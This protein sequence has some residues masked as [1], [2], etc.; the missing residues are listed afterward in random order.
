MIL[1]P[2]YPVSDLYRMVGNGT[3]LQ[4]D[5]MATLHGVRSFVSLRSRAE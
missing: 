1:K 2:Y 5:F 3:E 4:L